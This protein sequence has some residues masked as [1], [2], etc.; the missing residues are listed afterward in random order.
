MMADTAKNKRHHT[1]EG[2]SD[3]KKRWVVGNYNQTS[4]NWNITLS[5]SGD[6]C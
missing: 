6:N 2:L 5:S 3:T 1:G 4:L